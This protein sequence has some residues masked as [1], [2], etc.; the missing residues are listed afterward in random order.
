MRWKW[1]RKVRMVMQGD[2]LGVVEGTLSAMDVRLEWLHKVDTRWE[3][4]CK[5]GMV[6]RGGNGH[7]RYEPPSEILCSLIFV[8][9]DV[10][11]AIVIHQMKHTVKL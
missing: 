5:V 11:T 6:M 2:F 1:S 10:K 8:D 3:W 9:C 4:S 7:A